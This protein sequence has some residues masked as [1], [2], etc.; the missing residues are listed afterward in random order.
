MKLIGVIVT[1]LIIAGLVAGFTDALDWLGL[2]RGAT[3]N[4]GR[5][6]VD[7][8]GEGTTDFEVVPPSGWVVDLRWGQRLAE[9]V[10]P[11]VVVGLVYFAGLP[12]AG[13]V[14]DPTMMVLRQPLPAGDDLEAI[15]EGQIAA[16]E[17]DAPL[18]DIVSSLERIDG[19]PA[20]LLLVTDPPDADFPGGFVTAQYHVARGEEVWV[21]QCAGVS[22]ESSG[23]GDAWEA[24]GDALERFRFAPA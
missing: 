1:W 3:P 6:A 13:G 21:L 22:Q 11:S 24:C 20:V 10:D 9:Q 5:L 8:T 4:A 7:P 17:A 2:S 23:L 18:S 12:Y 19:L 16:L 15:V 14:Y